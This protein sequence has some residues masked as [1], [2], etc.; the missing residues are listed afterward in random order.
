MRPSRDKR[1]DR[2]YFDRWYRG[3]ERSV[4][5]GP[6]LTRKVH[7]AVAIA[8]TMTQRPLRSVLDVGC[9]EARWQP[10]LAAHRPDA[11]YL[12]LD[13]SPYVVERFGRRRNI[14]TGSFADLGDVAFERPF[15]L[16]VCADVLHYLPRSD[17]LEGLPRLAPLVGGAA[18]LEVF[19]RA[20]VIEGDREGLHLRR[21]ATYR[22]WFRDASLVPC[23]L[24]HYVRA[25]LAED[26]A[27][28]DL[29]EA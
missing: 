2:A 6:E 7:L 23:G 10:V 16:V 15:D 5:S 1:Y 22:R 8:E 26:L 28:L 12:G 20:D 18:L 21:P 13:P 3:P 14:L 24:Q 25:D 9:G 29:P 11:S 4:D 17:I 19:T 27:A